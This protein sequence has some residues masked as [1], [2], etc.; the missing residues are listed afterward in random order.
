MTQQE[1]LMGQTISDPDFIDK[2]LTEPET[3]LAD[4]AYA[5]LTHSDLQAFVETV[6][7]IQIKKANSHPVLAWGS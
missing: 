7:Q 2:L 3:I 6:K 1:R 5:G 4:P